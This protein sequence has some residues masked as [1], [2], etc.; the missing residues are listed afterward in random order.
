MPPTSPTPSGRPGLSDIIRQRFNDVRAQEAAAQEAER[1]RV[2]SMQNIMHLLQQGKIQGPPASNI[3]VAPVT[4]ADV[5]ELLDRRAQLNMAAQFV[6]AAREKHA[7]NPLP[8]RTLLAFVAKNGALLEH[9]GYT[10]EDVMAK[11][12]SPQYVISHA[13]GAVVDPATGHLRPSVWA[14]D[15]QIELPEDMA[16]EPLSFVP[17][18]DESKDLYF[19]QHRELAEKVASDIRAEPGC[20]AVLQDVSTAPYQ[21]D[22]PADQRYPVQEYRDKKLASAATSHAISRIE[23]EVNPE[24]QVPIRYLIAN[25]FRVPSVTLAEGPEVVFEDAIT[26]E[27]SVIVHSIARKS[28]RCCLAWESPQTKIVAPDGSII[29]AGWITAVR[30]IGRGA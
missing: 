15:A 5:P 3:E 11:V 14:A 26:N 4:T 30:L 28:Y 18:A 16:T 27:I 8:F 13:R 12:C 10:P 25:M 21:P 22:T 29:N 6:A 19:S 24:R 17:P 9:V 23:T 7:G 1:R 2:E 20:A